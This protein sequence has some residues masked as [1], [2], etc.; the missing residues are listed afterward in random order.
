MKGSDITKPEKQENKGRSPPCKTVNQI[1]IH[2]TTK[3]KG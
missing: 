1:E 3:K 2:S